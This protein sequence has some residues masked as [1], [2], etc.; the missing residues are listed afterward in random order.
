[1][2]VSRVWSYLEQSHACMTLFLGFFICSRQWSAEKK[3]VQ[4]MIRRA[5]ERGEGPPTPAE[6]LRDA[7]RHGEQEV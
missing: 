7:G 5:N 1:M 2:A 6:M 4:G 3:N